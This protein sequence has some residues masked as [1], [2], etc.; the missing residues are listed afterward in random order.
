MS[1]PNT[2]QEPTMEEILSSIR[3]IISEDEA[4]EEGA[5]APGGEEASDSAP[6]EAAAASGDELDVADTEPEIAEEPA[7]A[8]P[9][10]APAAAAEPE[11]V[12]DDEDGDFEENVFDLTDMVDEDGSTESL[13]EPAAEAAPEPEPEPEPEPDPEPA[14]EPEAAP[15]PEPA[16]QAS[17]DLPEDL[18]VAAVIDQSLVGSETANAARGSLSHLAQSVTTYRGLPMGAGDRTLEELVKEL[19]RPMLKQ[20]LD[21]NLVRIV[22]RLVEKE[23][24]KLADRADDE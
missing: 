8:E 23:I 15:E 2:D 24:S 20:F 9:E 3:R 6:D 5:S 4:P 21:E 7:P 18:A 16:P 12:P 17:G 22:Q 11:A 10:A 1:D 13:D 19:L 14:P